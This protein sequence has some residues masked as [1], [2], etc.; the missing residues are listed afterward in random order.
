MSDP[1]KQL[2]QTTMRQSIHETWLCGYQ[3]AVESMRDW[4]NEFGD[5][6]TKRAVLDCADMVEAAKPTK[7]MLSG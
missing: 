6:Q 2:S 4:A 5:E 7:E 1:Q 3:S